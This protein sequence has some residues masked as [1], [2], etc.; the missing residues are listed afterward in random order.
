MTP[1]STN[2]ARALDR[3]AQAFVAAERLG[4][5]KSMRRT[6]VVAALIAVFTGA[7]GFIVNDI[8]HFVGFALGALMMITAAL[9]FWRQSLT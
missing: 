2:D 8:G 7:A 3:A 5:R 1:D 6:A 9:I 4:Y